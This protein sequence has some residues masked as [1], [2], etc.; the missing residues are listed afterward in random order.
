MRSPYTALPGIVALMLFAVSLPT[1]A[2]APKLNVVASTTILQDIAQNIAGDK[3]NV[4]YLVPT[5]GDVHVFEPK[6]N[7][8]KK[9]A[10]ADLILVNGA[11]LEQFVDRLIEQSGTKGKVVVASQGL[12]IQRFESIQASTATPTTA[13]QSANA[14]GALPGNIIGVSGS[15][16]CGAPQAGQGIDECDPH[17][18]QN[19]TNVIGYAINIRDALSAADPANAGTYNANAGLY[20]ARLQ[21]LDADI[22]QGLEKIPAANRILVTNHD[23][24]GYFLTR[25]GLQIAGV[26]LP[27]GATEQ[28]PDPKQMADLIQVIRAKNVKAIFLENVSNDRLARQIAEQ[29]GVKVVQALY[30][31]AL[32]AKGTPGDTYIGMM[33]ANLKTLQ[34]ALQ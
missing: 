5:D 6:P 4:D 33:Y 14:A 31:D 20:I 30:T 17:L 9:I 10:D 8:V 28:E 25:Y 7:D 23:A 1:S 3:A 19:V 12:P 18:W 34:D 2:Q 16:Q 29:A 11:G 21:K 27:G 13:A 24:L 32:G 22:F 26:V 15:F